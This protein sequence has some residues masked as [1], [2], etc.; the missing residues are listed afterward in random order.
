M[1][2][3]SVE[4]CSRRAT[5]DSGFW[6]WILDSSDCYVTCEP[7]SPSM[8]QEGDL[9]LRILDLDSGLPMIAASSARKM[10]SY[11]IRPMAHSDYQARMHDA[12]LTAGARIAPLAHLDHVASFFKAAVSIA[13]GV[14]RRAASEW[15][16]LSQR[17]SQCWSICLR[18]CRA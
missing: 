3:R 11:G 10:A 12:L 18:S 8:L 2:L 14:P 4:V 16:R 7:H 17:A 15:A 5:L 13:V 1:D 6:I 9:G